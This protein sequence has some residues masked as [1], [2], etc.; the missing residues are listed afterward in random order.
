MAVI[1]PILVSNGGI[2]IDYTDT[3]RDTQ[4]RQYRWMTVDAKHGITL[5]MFWDDVWW[6]SFVICF[7]FSFCFK[8]IQLLNT[9]H[10]SIRFD[11]FCHGGFVWFCAADTK[12]GMMMWTAILTALLKVMLMMTMM[13]LQ[14]LAHY[15]RICSGKTCS[16]CV[17]CR[18]LLLHVVA[19]WMALCLYSCIVLYHQRIR[20]SAIATQ[21]TAMEINIPASS[22][23]AGPLWVQAWKVQGRPCTHFET[24]SRHFEEFCKD[25]RQNTAQNPMHNRDKRCG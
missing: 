2:G 8:E 14:M 9:F 13:S 25:S 20:V 23:M 22:E 18:P 10:M 5:L 6:I 12:T 7:S 19:L 4:H 3:R 15:F 1:T 24:S 21:N 17:P 16:L 11:Q